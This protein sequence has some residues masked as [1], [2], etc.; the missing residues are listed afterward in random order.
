MPEVP[1]S[2]A[3][4]AFAPLPTLVAWSIFAYGIV[5]KV[6]LP[7]LAESLGYGQG[8]E[9]APVVILLAGVHWT[10]ACVP[11][12]L[13]G[14][15]VGVVHPL[16]FPMLFS[17]AKE[18][19]FS[20][21]LLVAPFFGEL[22]LYA[23]SQP[24]ASLALGDVGFDDV[25][26]A[27]TLHQAAEVV[28][29]VAFYTG[30]IVVAQ[31]ETRPA[32]NSTAPPIT[33][34]TIAAV[35]WC[36]ASAVALFG[37]VQ[38]RGGLESHL[39]QLTTPRYAQFESAGHLVLLIKS[40]GIAAL[41]LASFGLTIRA[42]LM[43][44]VTG[45]ALLATFLV[46]GAR[47]GPIYVVVLL[48]LV[49]IMVTRRLPSLR[50]SAAAY[51]AVVLIGALGLIRHDWNANRVRWEVLNPDQHGAWI[52]KAFFEVATRRSEEADVAVFAR[53][54]ETGSLGGRS[55]LGAALF[56]VPRSL[57]P[58]KPRTAG[59][60]NNHYNF[61]RTYLA[62]D[63]PQGWG[64]PISGPTEAYWNF[65]WVGVLVVFF[66]TGGILRVLARWMHARG[67]RGFSAV[68]LATGLLYLDGTGDGFT[69]F[70]QHACT[71]G[72]IAV[73][74]RLAQVLLGRFRRP[75]RVA[76]QPSPA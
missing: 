5:Y 29:L 27:R 34:V 65:G 8:S 71:L 59:V 49:R 47:T 72:A 13:F 1:V 14:S 70:A 69:R 67:G 37:F 62:Q 43:A 68:L 73:T 24:S 31:I 20:P 2:K 40:A 57:W 38:V 42:P 46:D 45:Y 22:H 76:P 39:V 33:A 35:A 26:V 19:V 55:Y 11:L 51:L 3:R 74:A 66:G 12:L 41:A 28:A 25:M 61:S 60:Y 50:L 16:A 30:Y 17:T 4:S 48:L 21:A 23:V 15:K 10:L 54:E 18:I 9:F 52:E 58:E 32:Q 75:A 64:I 36:A 56:F 53:R 7:A 63:F 44:L 6:V